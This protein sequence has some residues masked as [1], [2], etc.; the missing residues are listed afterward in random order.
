MRQT[1]TLNAQQLS[2]AVGWASLA[3]GLLL[4]LDPDFSARLF[5]MGDQ[6]R[7]IGFGCGE[8]LTL[9]VFPLDQG[10][11]KRDRT[12]L[13]SLQCTDL[14]LEVCIQLN[15]RRRHGENG[16]APTDRVKRADGGAGFR[17][18]GGRLHFGGWKPPLR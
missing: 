17:A 18:R 9:A 10:A 16:S 1:I 8:L 11:D 4:F 12:L 2:R 15:G 13:R 14:F 5:G 7:L 6:Q 3:T